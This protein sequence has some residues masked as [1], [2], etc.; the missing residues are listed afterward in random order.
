MSL[1]A[2]VKR[3]NRPGPPE[4]SITLR[5][6]CAGAVITGIVACRAEGELSW[7]VAG[8]SV[9]LVVFGMV[10]AYRTREKPL[11]WI[12]PI[13]ALSALAAFLWFFRQLTGQTIYDVSTVENPLAVLFVWVQ[14]AHAFDVPARRDLAFSLAG[15]GQPHG[16][17]R[18]PGQST[19][20]L[21]VYVL[22]WLACGLTGLVAMWGSASEGGRLR[23][24]A[25]WSPRWD[26]LS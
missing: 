4:H 5:V 22:V 7:A 26:P 25:A 21:G 20:A 11:P 23:A 8:G 3:A 6:A 18:G 2:A 9:T 1:F 15:V 17:G 19:S 10:L 14:V 16:R 24:R 12:K 13:L